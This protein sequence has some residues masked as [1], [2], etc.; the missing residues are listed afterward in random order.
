MFVSYK[1]APLDLLYLSNFL[2]TAIVPHICDS[3]ATCIGVTMMLLLIII[4]LIFLGITAYV[5]ARRQ[6]HGG[7]AGGLAS[8]SPPRRASLNSGKIFT[9]EQVAKHNTSNNLWLIINNKV[10]D[11][12][13]YLPL[14]PGG[15]AMLRNAGRDSTSG[16]SGPQHEP[17][18]WDMV[19]CLSQKYIHSIPP[20]YSYSTP[21]TIWLT[22]YL[23]HYTHRSMSF[24]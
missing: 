20:P 19:S 22:L 7:L 23:F 21:H 14:H 3:C 16:F 10:Y 12:T 4:V 6:K 11:F 8:S 13:E 24:T 9:A 18:V 2:D 5:V 17:R 15:E 1:T